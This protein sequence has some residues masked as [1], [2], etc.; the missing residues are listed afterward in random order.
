VNQIDLLRPVIK[1]LEDVELEY[2]LVGSFASSAW[3]EPRLTQDVN[4]V[5]RLDSFDAERPCH[6]FSADEFYISK[7]AAQEAVETVGE[8]NLIHPASGNKDDF[9]LVGTSPWNDSQLARR[10]QTALFPNLRFFYCRTGGCHS[11]KA[12]LLS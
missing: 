12:S 9:M 2:A 10:R 6:A 8:F 5:V 7:T 1:T 4:F 3:G 11:G